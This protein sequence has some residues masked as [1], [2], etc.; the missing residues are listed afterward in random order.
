VTTVSE[1]AAGRV[2]AADLVRRFGD[3]DDDANPLGDAAVLA[4]DE[5]GELPADGERMLDDYGLNAEF[6]PAA[7]GGRFHRAD[8]LAQLVRAVFRRDAS[9]GIGYGVTSFIAGVPIWASGS[10]AQQRAAAATLLSGGRIAAAYTELDHGS[11]FSR[12]G[13][14]ARRGDDPGALVLS[15]GKQLVNNVGRAESALLF[16]RT[17]DRPGPRSHSHLL[18]DLT[19]LPG[20]TRDRRYRTSGVRGCRI[21]GI[22]F[23][24]SPVP[25]SALVGEPGGAMETVLRAFQVTRSV[26]PGMVVGMVDTQLRTVL[27][28]V[29]RRRVYG[30][31]VADLP[32]ARAA[33]TGA[34]FDLVAADALA[35]TG[36][37]ALHVLPEQASVHSA[38][39]KYLVPKLLHDASYQLSVVLGAR[40]YLREGPYAIFQKMTRDLAAVSLAHAGSAVCQATMVPQLPRLAE[41]S[42]LR[43]GPPPDA[44]F[45][46]DEPLPPLDFTRLAVNARGQDNIPAALESGHGDPLLAPLSGL[47]RA[48]LERLAPACAALPPKDRTVA[49]GRRAFHLADRYATVL[50]AASVCGVSRYSADKALLAGALHRLAGR[51][52][53]EPDPLPAEVERTVFDSLL[54]RYADGRTFDLAGT[55]PA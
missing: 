24:E 30:R 33:L 28:F 51:L 40:S 8:E 13:L 50:A 22:S 35:T 25:V 42:W 11:D 20:M 53:L 19:A 32:L 55:K 17:D 16:A 1:E 15:G 5:R 48:E 6:V 36:A 9:L 2:R 44:L 7:L 23:A 12:I 52:A 41:R 31:P 43:A 27:R 26:L 14:T 10:L 37:R 21:G 45:A 4:A 49:A 3:P 38:A 18:V 54:D 39:V 47:F 34:W 29:L 46:P